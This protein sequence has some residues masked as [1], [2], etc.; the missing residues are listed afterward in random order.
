MADELNDRNWDANQHY[1]NEKVAKEY[2]AVRFSSLAGRVFNNWERSIIKRCF[3][4]LPRETVVLD[5]PCGTGRLADALLESGLR[6][7]GADVSSEMLDVAKARLT[8]YGER[9]TTEVMDAFKQTG[10]KPRFE[11]TLCARVLMHFPLE[12]QIGFLR[13]VAS[14]TRST[15]VLNHCLNSPYQRFRRWVKKL[16]GHQESAGYPVTYDEISRLLAESGLSEVTRYRMNAL[17]SEAV[18]VV[19]KKIN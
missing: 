2:D 9:F 6:V 5:L 14:N 19:A 17:I 13:G 4:D 15:V 3:R 11:A 16:L 12:T 7:H 8:A 1:K 10:A 18:Y